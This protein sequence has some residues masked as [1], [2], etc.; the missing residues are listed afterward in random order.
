VERT[1]FVKKPDAEGELF[2]LREIPFPALATTGS[3]GFSEDGGNLD[4]ID[5]S[6]GKP[7]SA[8]ISITVLGGS[9][10][11]ADALTKVVLNLPADRAAALLGQYGCSALILESGGRFRELP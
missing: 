9:C 6:G 5:S 2:E 1:A 10:M 11:L 7:V 8:V 3:Y 4:L